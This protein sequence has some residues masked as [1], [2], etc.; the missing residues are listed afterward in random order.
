MLGYIAVDVSVLNK[1]SIKIRFRHA[2]LVVDPASDTGKTTSDAIVLLNGTNSDLS[3][4]ADYRI[5]ISGPGE[6]EINGVKVAGVRI[7]NGFVYNIIGD[8][9]SI[10]LG[11]TKE[12]SKLKEEFSATCQIA[13]LNVD[14]EF[15]QAVLTGL[16]P[17]VVVL[18]GDNKDAGAKILDKESI[19]S[20]R[21]FSVSKDKLPEEREVV[22]LG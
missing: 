6:Y 15:T 12:V 8:G 11:K 13:I 18:Y 20:L 5:V 17:K 7:D 1:S 9:L 22:T 16:E 10:V 2:T 4:V 14:S 19:S 21:K 3:K